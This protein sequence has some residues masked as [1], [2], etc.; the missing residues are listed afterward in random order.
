MFG[1]FYEF[2]G[3]TKHPPRIYEPPSTRHK[4]KHKSENGM[5]GIEFLNEL[6]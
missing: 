4:L 6:S 2:V 1:L 5:A 3:A